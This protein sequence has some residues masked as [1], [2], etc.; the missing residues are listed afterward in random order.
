MSANGCGICP[1]CTS[2]KA[3]RGALRG[4]IAID[5]EL[6][7][8]WQIIDG[9]RRITQSI[10]N[11]TAWLSTL[12]RNGA[13]RLVM[14]VVSRQALDADS[15]PL[16]VQTREAIQTR[17]RSDAARVAQFDDPARCAFLGVAGYLPCPPAL[18]RLTRL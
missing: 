15:E 16:P 17:G 7:N 6:P 9:P 1:S 5:T 2:P 18:A 3:G 4:S 8:P 10:V 11:G 14:V 12:E 13:D